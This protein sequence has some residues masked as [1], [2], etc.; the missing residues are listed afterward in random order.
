MLPQNLN[1]ARRLLLQ[2]ETQGFRDD[3]DNV[4]VDAELESFSGG[5]LPRLALR[6]SRRGR[7]LT[8]VYGYQTRANMNADSS[9][10]PYVAAV[11][12]ADPTNANNDLYSYQSPNWTADTQ[13]GMSSAFKAVVTAINASQTLQST[14]PTP[15]APGAGVPAD[16]Q[17]GKFLGFTSGNPAWLGGVW[18]DSLSS[19]S[20]TTPGRTKLPNGLIVQWGYATVNGDA[21]LPFPTTFPTLCAAVVATPQATI[22]ATETLSVCVRDVAAGSFV[23]EVRKTSGGVV[24]GASSFILFVAVGF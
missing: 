9:R 22:A 15:G 3:P 12:F 14:M 8:T 23:G 1:I 17:D 7:W 19:I 16:G 6:I 10:D 2:W 13:W 20:Y 18:T 11:V 5:S 21:T 4:S 24:S